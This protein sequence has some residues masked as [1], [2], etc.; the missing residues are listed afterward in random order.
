M[1]VLLGV[2][3]QFVWSGRELVLQLPTGLHSLTVHLAWRPLSN[4]SE[5]VCCQERQSYYLMGFQY[6]YS[7]SVDNNAQQSAS[8]V[9][10]EYISPHT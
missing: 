3:T 5:L 7:P 10:V 2:V 8:V 9:L 4:V 6:N 1:M